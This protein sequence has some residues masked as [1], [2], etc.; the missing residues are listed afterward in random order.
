MKKRLLRFV[1]L[2]LVAFMF[3]LNLFPPKTMAYVVTSSELS[4]LRTE[5][6]SK[7]QRVLETKVVK[8][9]LKEFGLTEEEIHS[10]LNALTDEELHSFAQNIEGL[11]PGGDGLGLIIGLLIIAILVLV[12]LHLTD[13]KIVIE[14]D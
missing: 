14:K 11:Y 13:H 5:D 2:Y 7:I 9:R 1:A 10:K 12:I 6:M 4:S 3:A 8:E